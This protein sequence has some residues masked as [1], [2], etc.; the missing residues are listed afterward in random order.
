MK[1][2]SSYKL[3]FKGVVQGVGFRPTVYRV[4]KQ[5]DSHGYVLNTGSEVE[6]VIDTDPEEFIQEIKKNLSSLAHISSVETYP[7]QRRFSNFQIKKSTQGSKQSLI[8]VDTA[9]CDECLAELFDEQNR[10]YQYPFTNCTVCGARYSVITNVPYDRKHT[11]MDEFPLCESC[12][13]EYSNPLD[14]RY[15]AQTISCPRCGPSYSVFDSQQNE[16]KTTDPIAVFATKIDAGNIGVIKSWGGMHLCCTLSE[17]SRFRS[18]YH[19]PQKSFAVMVQNLDFAHQ[20]ADITND[21]ENLLTSSQRPIVLVKKK[22]E[23]NVAPGLDYIG[24]FLPYTPVH[25]LLFHRLKNN[26]LV[27]TSANIPGEPMITENM[28]V[29]DLHADLYLL[30]N[31]RIPNRVDDS[32]IK[33]WE[34]NKFFIRKSRGYVPD[35]IPVSY[36]AHVVSVGPGENVTGAVSAHKTLYLTQYIGNTS[37]YE[38]LSFLEDSIHHLMKLTMEKEQIDAV[39]MDKHPGY[40][41]KKL[42]TRFAE[43]FQVPLFSFQHHWAHA[44]SLLLDAGESEAVVLSLDGLGYGED[45]LLWGSEVIASSFTDY[46]RISHCEP[47]PLLGGDKAAMDPRRVVFAVFDQFDEEIFFSGGDAEVFRKIMPRSP[48]STSFGRIL[49]ALSCYLGICCK[50]TYDGEPAMK[51]ERYLAKGAKRYPFTA[52]VSKGIVQTV[53]LFQ[54]LHE[55]TKKVSSPL[56]EK[57]KADLAFSF[58]DSLISALANQAIDYAEGHDIEHI[59]VSGGVSYNIPIVEMI[60]AR[61]KQHDLGFLVHNT[62][63][64]GDGGISAGQNVLAGYKMV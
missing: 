28:D 3:V 19:R 29:F 49:D 15:H 62:I 18:W 7:D 4:A 56:S 51:L 1:K 45:E 53:D 6:V 21:E 23:L 33:L 16:I 54:Q 48:R 11:A 32:V 25:Y 17:I 8:P 36:D 14:R 24:L 59:G 30:H 64:N 44:A 41:T 52:K 39:A 37:S 55:T 20:L 47:I 13:K 26:A 9:I 2:H 40:E 46:K 27:M 50:R 43:R 61:V 22:K 12:Q 42:A 63:P 34:N 10:R 35:P 5:L 38:T 31:R 58:V 60:N 57:N